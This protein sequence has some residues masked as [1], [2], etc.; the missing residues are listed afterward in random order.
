MLLGCATG[1]DSPRVEGPVGDAQGRE[2]MH[3]VAVAGTGALIRMRLCRPA[4]GAGSL[5]VINHGSPPVAANGATMVPSSCGGEVVSWFS[6]RGYAVALP[7]R[8]GY[9]AS[10][11]PYAENSSCP[12]AAFEHAGRES[13]R[14]VSAAIGY[15]R[16]LPGV[17]ADA[18]VVVVGQSAGGWASLALASGNPAG[19]AAIVNMAGGRGGWLQNTPNNNC[20]PDLLA[21]AAGAF[22]RTARMPVLS[23]Y[24]TN[25]GFFAPPLVAISIQRAYTDA[26]GV[27][28]ARNLPAFGSDDYALFFARG[29]SAIWEPEVE[30]F[31]APMGP[32]APATPGRT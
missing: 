32:I 18:P 15:A 24:T 23:I 30:R 8:R 14:D 7:L 2:Q 11:G 19:I 10:D 9:G 12:K 31:L 26:G 28:E 25:D 20:R 6:A 27:M 4:A 17:R 1:A 5:V 3:R 16:N 21:A 13:A 29:G 22:G